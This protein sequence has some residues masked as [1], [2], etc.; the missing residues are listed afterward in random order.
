MQCTAIAAES[1][2]G[3]GLEFSPK[4]CACACFRNS[5]FS[6]FK[7]FLAYALEIRGLP[8]AEDFEN[9]ASAS[10][11]EALKSCGRRFGRRFGKLKNFE[12]FLS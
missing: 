3:S 10:A 11:T 1:T 9:S 8:K 12:N 2:Q 7:A 5:K 6:E 4:K